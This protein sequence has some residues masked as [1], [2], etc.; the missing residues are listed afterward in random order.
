MTTLQAKW[1]ETSNSP[2]FSD[3]F[4]K[5]EK[6]YQNIYEEKISKLHLQNIETK[7][8]EK[9]AKRK[10]EEV[11]RNSVLKFSEKGF[12]V[13]EISETLELPKKKVIEILEL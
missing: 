10:E 7:R 6:I 12:S 3:V 8:K 11:I 4:T 1:K 13:K 2:V 5:L 9:E